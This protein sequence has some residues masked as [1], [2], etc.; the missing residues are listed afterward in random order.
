MRCVRFGPCPE[1]RTRLGRLLASEL[2]DCA[3]FS[4]A[5]DSLN[6]RMREVLHVR[7]AYLPAPCW[8]PALHVWDLSRLHIIALEM[9]PTNFSLFVPP[10]CPPKCGQ[11]GRV[12]LQQTL[13]GPTVILEW[14]CAACDAEWPVIRKEVVPAK[15]ATPENGRV[16]RKRRRR[17]S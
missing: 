14:C 4:A 2:L 3:V 15:A 11:G 5:S 12:N 13:K 7:G 17:P 8:P 1:K 9:R 6:R 10:V 16:R